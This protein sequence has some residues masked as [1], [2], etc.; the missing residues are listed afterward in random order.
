MT[1][2]NAIRVNDQFHCGNCGKQ[3]DVND[4][5]VPDCKMELISLEPLD[6]NILYFGLDLIVPYFMDFIYTNEYGDICISVNEPEIKNDRWLN[7]GRA[8]IIARV[9]LHGI[10]WRETLRKV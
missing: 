3:W 9:N 1:H 7:R 5:D 8:I 2:A 4:N 6:K 10:N